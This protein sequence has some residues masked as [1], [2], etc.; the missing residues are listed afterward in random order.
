MKNNCGLH[1]VPCAK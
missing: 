1:N